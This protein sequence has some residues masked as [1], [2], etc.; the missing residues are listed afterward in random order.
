MQGLSISGNCV[1]WGLGIHM[2]FFCFIIVLFFEIKNLC[3]KEIA[4]RKHIYDDFD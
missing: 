2:D 1:M 3:L 4:H